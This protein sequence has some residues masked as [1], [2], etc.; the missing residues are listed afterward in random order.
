MMK[1]NYHG[2]GKI[3]KTYDRKK[4]LKITVDGYTF[5]PDLDFM[6]NHAVCAYCGEI[7]GWRLYK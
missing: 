4:R 5:I 1:K 3:E 6:N 2:E 7:Y